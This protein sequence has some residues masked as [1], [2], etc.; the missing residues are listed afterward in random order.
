MRTGIALGSNIGDRLQ[1]LR[2]ARKEV[3]A[4]QGASAE[5]ARSSRVYETEPVNCE[6]TQMALLLFRP[7]DP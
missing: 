5:T 3:L 4:L 2:D 7:V 1:N 6:L